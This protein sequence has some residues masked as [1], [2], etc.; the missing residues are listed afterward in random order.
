VRFQ[1]IH[2]AELRRW[3][4]FA[5]P[6]IEDVFRICRE[7]QIPEDV[8]FCLKAER[9]YLHVL[10]VNDQPCGVAVTEL[11]GEP[12]AR[13]MNVWALHFKQKV[14]EHRGE[15]LQWLDGMAKAAQ[16]SSI[17]FTSPRAWAGLLRD[18]F[19][20]KSVIYERAVQ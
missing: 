5:R 19:K 7:P 12:D 9:A 6:L 13:F 20:E 1:A 4:G 8:W 17:R 14:D 11:C 16:V 18:D 2:P 10:F 3:W 15:I